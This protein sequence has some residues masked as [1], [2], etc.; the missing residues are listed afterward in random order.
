[1]SKLRALLWLGA[2]PVCVIGAA[3]QAGRNADALI[4]EGDFE[5]GDLRGWN[6]ERCC[7]HSI[8]VVDE[9]VRVGFSLGNLRYSA[10]YGHVMSQLTSSVQLRPARADDVDRVAEIEAV[11]FPCP[12]SKRM[13][14][15]EIVSGGRTRFTVAISPSSG[16]VLGYISYSTT[17][18]EIHILTLA[19]DPKHRRQGIARALLSACLDAGRAQ[20]ATIAHLEVRESNVAAVNLYNRLGFR[21]LGRRARYYVKP[22]EDALLFSLNLASGSPAPPAEPS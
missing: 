20:G 1:M 4:F 15:K 3:A 19:T 6:K 16:E 8:K 14:Q 18:E 2:L 13:I 5:S 11:S 12:W 10:H 7:D 9:P 17:P 22:V 21:Q